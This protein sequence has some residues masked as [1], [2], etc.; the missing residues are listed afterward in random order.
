MEESTAPDTVPVGRS[1]AA[2]A[3]AVPVRTSDVHSPS[4]PP[5]SNIHLRR[6]V[7]IVRPVGPFVKCSR[8][9]ADS[10]PYVLAHN[11]FD[12]QHEI[13]AVRQGRRLEAREGLAS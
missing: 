4:G 13:G 10:S 9:K 8:P 5:I 7:Q 2:V 12:L 11:A 6:I 3:G 1:A